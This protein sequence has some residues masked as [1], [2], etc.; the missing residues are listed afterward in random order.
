MVKI[1]AFVTEFMDK[2]LDLDSVKLNELYDALEA[3][4]G[5]CRRPLLMRAK[6]MVADY[7][8]RKAQKEASQ[9]QKRTDSSKPLKQRRWSQTTSKGKPRR[10]PARDKRGPTHP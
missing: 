10:R 7:I 6:A 5:P 9:G 1:Q 2:V 4:F 3:K 8:Q